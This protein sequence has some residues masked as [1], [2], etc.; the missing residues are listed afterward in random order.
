MLF[1]HDATTVCKRRL[2]SDVRILNATYEPEEKKNEIVV[3]RYVC[4]H[5]LVGNTNSRHC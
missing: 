4:E 3:Q 2:Y 5:I 1:N